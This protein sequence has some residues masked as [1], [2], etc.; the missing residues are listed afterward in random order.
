[1]RSNVFDENLVG[2]VD[3]VHPEVFMTRIL[4]KVTHSRVGSIPT[5]VAIGDL[6]SFRSGLDNPC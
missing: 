4:M 2:L 1:M 3:L 6:V 5:Y